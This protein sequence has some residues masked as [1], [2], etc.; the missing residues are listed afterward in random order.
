M[1]KSVCRH[2]AHDRDPKTFRELTL[3]QDASVDRRTGE[4]PEED[5]TNLP[6]SDEAASLA[7]IHRDVPVPALLE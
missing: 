3:A 4:P 6:G 2:P 5:A 1:I 7:L